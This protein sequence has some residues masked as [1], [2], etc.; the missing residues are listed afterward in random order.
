MTYSHRWRPRSSLAKAGPAWISAVAALITAL[1]AVGFFTTKG[2]PSA[3]SPG[4][5]GVSATA[6]PSAHGTS[7]SPAHVPTSA[8]RVASGKRLTR[9]TVD[10]ADGYGFILS[11]RPGRPDRDNDNDF[12]VLNGQVNAQSVQ[13][14]MLDPGTDVSY[15]ACMADTRYASFLPVNHGDAFCMTGK[16]Y[17]AGVKVLKVELSI[18]GYIRMDVTIWRA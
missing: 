12:L 17:V 14:A 5:T 2:T 18:P 9:Y 7:A 16:D 3:G 6:T 11:D 4:S 8:A 1:A 10:V 15:P 13:L